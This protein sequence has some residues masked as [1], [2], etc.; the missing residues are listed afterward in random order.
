MD[1]LITYSTKLIDNKSEEL[2]IQESKRNPA[3][4][5]AIY[6]KYY[7]PIY[8]LVLNKV[9]DKEV[10]GD[11]VADIFCQAL[12][13]LKKF[14]YKGTSIYFWIYR[15]AL[16]GCNEYFRK[17]GRTKYVVLDED[18][19]DQLAEE[20]T[21]TDEDMILILKYALKKLSSSE[22]QYIELRFFEGLKFQEI[23]SIMN[24][25]EAQC[26]MKVY[27]AIKRLKKYFTHER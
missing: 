9:R 5:E 15:I 27:R 18:R 1:D 13:N 6:K 4:F 21:A 19:I 16:N 3:K 20:I 12:H 22:L 25:N 17:S 7:G 26:K 8:R 2:I 24:T 11:L 23:A 10:A 14:S